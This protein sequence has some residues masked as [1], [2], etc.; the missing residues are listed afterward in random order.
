ML[1]LAVAYGALGMY[2]QAAKLYKEALEICETYEERIRGWR[3]K[4]PP[5]GFGCAAY[6]TS[7][8]KSYMDQGDYAR[9]EPLLRRSIEFTTNN[10]ADEQDQI[11]SI[12]PTVAWER[13][14]LG[15]IFQT[16]GRIREAEAQYKSALAI[17][18]RE[19]KKWQHHLGN[20]SKRLE[21]FKGSYEKAVSYAHL[22]IARV[23]NDLAELY[24]G[25]GRH[26]EAGALLR[27]S[28]NTITQHVG[29]NS[30]EFARSLITLAAVYESEGRK[31]EAEPLYK[32]ALSMRKNSF[33]ASHPKVA[34]ILDSLSTFYRGHGRY[35]EALSHI[36]RAT[37]IHRDHAARLGAQRSNAVLHE[38]KKARQIFI[39]HVQTAWEISKRQP[40]KSVRLTEEAFEAAQLTQAT[41]AAIAVANMGARFAAGD[42]DLALIVRA[43]QDAVEERR[44]KDRVLAS[45]LSRRPDQRNRSAETRLRREI[46]ALDRKLSDLDGRLSRDFPE[47]AELS[48]PRPIPLEEIQKL[49]APR[50]ALLTYVVDDDETFL[51]VVRK[52]R[53]DMFRLDI[54]QKALDEAVRSLRTGLDLGLSD[55][56]AFDTTQAFQLY[57]QVFASA[58]PLLDGIGHVFVMP[59]GPLQSL[60]LG[61]LVTEKPQEKVTDFSGYQQV[62]WLA[63]K[64]A[65]TTL[66]SVSSLRALRKFA[67]VAQASKPFGGFGD[68]L[69]EGHPGKMRGIPIKKF[70]KPQGGANVELVRSVLPPLPETADELNAMA[71]SLGAGKDSLFLR[72]RAT[73]TAVKTTDLSDTRVLAFA[74]HA[75]VAGE[76]AGMAEPALVLTPPKKGT[77]KDDGLLTASEVATLKLD[78][79]LVILS[80][81]N[82]AASDGTPN[83]DALSGLAKAFFYA[84]SRAL[85]VSH[86]PVESDAT[87]R[88]TTGMLSEM[89]SHP[90]LGRAEALR[91]SMLA[92]MADKKTPQ[93]AHPAYWAPFVVVGEGSAGASR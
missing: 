65:L 14:L 15:R 45:M 70:Y 72:E 44:Q 26:A 56:P 53:A 73:E 83:A 86:W 22:S 36:R 88:L 68:P 49:L 6:V 79:D 61:V 10:W 51:W 67:K 8:A 29:I 7:L 27:R 32:R 40:A 92:L 18:E 43:R 75:L 39:N 77:E 64:Y 12:G 20:I 82:T 57:R 2:D 50:E 90:G 19:L 41:G 71:R 4:F 60:P 89:A 35:G 11:A 55:S 25:Q 37:A 91:R 42:D 16:Q 62:P 24:E 28:I 23:L 3:R 46:E 66:P 5:K 85:L 93:F 21:K 74:T 63:R 78:A 9:A 47:Y 52:D 59:D 54:G 31:D 17:F 1:Q 81:C 33:G 48:S 87:V 30:P 76:L 84:G 38:Q 58:E 13:R 69:L 34:K 80:A